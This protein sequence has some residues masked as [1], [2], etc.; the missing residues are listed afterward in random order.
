LDKSLPV[1]SQFRA[2]SFP[3]QFTDPPW[4]CAKNSYS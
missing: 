3:F 1:K 2:Q 4:V